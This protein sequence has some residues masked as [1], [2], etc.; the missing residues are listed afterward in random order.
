M[1]P[2][3]GKAWLAK[4]MKDQAEKMVMGVLREVDFTLCMCGHKKKS[5]SEV[6]KELGEGK[7][8]YP[9]YW[10]GLT[11]GGLDG[12]DSFLNIVTLDG[13]TA[14]LFQ[15][16]TDR[17]HHKIH[18]KDRKKHNPEN[19]AMP[20][21][22]VVQRVLRCENSRT[23]RQFGTR[24]AMQ[25]QNIELAD[26]KKYDV[27]SSTA[28]TDL[29]RKVGSTESFCNEWYLFHGTSPQAAVN[30]CKNNFKIK[31]AGGHTGTLYG[32]G[33]YFTESITKAD[34]YASPN[35]EGEYAA[36]MCRVLGGNVRYTDQVSPNA[37]D[38]V[39]SCIKGPYDSVLGDRKKC[40]GTYREFVVFDTEDM[41]A[42]YVIIYKREY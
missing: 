17:T 10:S 16:L 35:A 19:P 14:S 11:T 6:Y 12:D 1:T 37:E 32:R 3:S 7:V 22:Y 34:E 25:L 8:P 36:L 27:H 28:W 24:R 20:S 41:Y 33:I 15:E 42:E 4:S 40:R 38:L 9:F 5:H 18:T 31:F 29:A 13:I 39:Q 23:W 30:I 21:R 26:V 2:K